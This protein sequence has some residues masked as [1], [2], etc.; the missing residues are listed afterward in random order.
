MTIPFR[1]W[2][3]KISLFTR[4]TITS[5]DHF[6]REECV[7]GFVPFKP[8]FYLRARREVPRA[9]FVRS[10]TRGPIVLRLI[11][12]EIRRGFIPA[13]RKKKHSQRSKNYESSF[14]KREKKVA[15]GKGRLVKFAYSRRQ[16]NCRMQ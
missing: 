9:K 14:H 3:D 10:R 4:N 6:Y 13:I 11:T 15:S 12:S 16:E 7:G 5:L 8:R 2:D 1:E